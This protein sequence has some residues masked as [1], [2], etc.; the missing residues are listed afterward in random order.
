MWCKFLHHIQL[1]GL[2]IVTGRFLNILRRRNS[3]KHQAE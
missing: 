1:L 2:K 3:Y